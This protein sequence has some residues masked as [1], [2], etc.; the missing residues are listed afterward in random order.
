MSAPGQFIGGQGRGETSL[1]ARFV[2]LAIVCLALM[3][4]DHQESHLA[5][6]R[7]GLSVVVYPIQ[8]LVDLPFA[9]W[10]SMRGWVTERELLLAENEQLKRE[11]L[12]VNFRL[13][14]LDAL[15]VENQ[16]LRELL[17]STA[18]LG[19]RVLIAQIL[20]VD[21]DPYRQ[22][23]NLDRGLADGVYVG[24][25]LLDAAGVVGQ[26]VEVGPLTAEA[27][28]ITDADHAVPVS[29]NRNG[30]RTI[31][32]GTGDSS[33][34]RLPYLTNSADIEVGDLLV[35]SGLGGVFP[36]GYPVGR[37]I[38][39]RIRPGQSFAEVIAK[40][41]SELDRDQEVLLVWTDED[42]PM[43]P[44]ARLTEVP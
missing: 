8:V 6:L 4:L 13:Q 12:G 3:L 9:S 27:V 36:S 18:V 33:R 26:V 42:E 44:T 39:V 40:P 28:L 2:L 43:P 35:S 22:R 38:E 25:A 17:D 29:V 34:L 19:H 16:R 30:L 15:E 5:R 24:Q 32:V 23:F 21:L 11:R 37:V 10:Q 14:R 31:A 20:A 1:G 41:V 7:Q